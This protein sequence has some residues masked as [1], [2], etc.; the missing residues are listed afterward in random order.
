MK[1]QVIAADELAWHLAA[2]TVAI[3]QIRSVAP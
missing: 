2:V 1:S 3:R